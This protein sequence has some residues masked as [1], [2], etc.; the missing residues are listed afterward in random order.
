MKTSETAAA[1]RSWA[2]KAALGLMGAG[3]V[4]LLYVLFAA[5]SKPDREA[6]S[7]Y[8]SGEMRRLVVR[9]D[10]PP[11]P[12]TLLRNA[13]GAETNLAAYR[14]EVVLV[15]F[16]ATWCPPCMEE[17]PTLAA[18]NR[19]FEGRGFRVVPV[20]IDSEARNEAAQTML[21]RYGEGLPFL[22]DPTRAIAFAAEAGPMPTSILYDRQ[23]REIARLTGEADWSSPE[24]RALVEAALTEN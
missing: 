21:R 12:R 13:A 6:F 8:A 11:Q 10:A 3:V 5:S 23:G 9:P 22:I 1:P 20:S 24:A 2:L 18:L 15:N 7:Q 14:G 19:D 16:W 17:L 4:A